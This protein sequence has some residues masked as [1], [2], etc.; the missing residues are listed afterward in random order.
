MH[1]KTPRHIFPD[2]MDGRNGRESMAAGWTSERE[3]RR[4]QQHG[5][6]VTCNPIGVQAVS[7]PVG[8]TG[9]L[10][11]AMLNFNLHLNNFFRSRVEVL[12]SVLLSHADQGLFGVCIMQ[13]GGAK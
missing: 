13:T 7:D 8:R 5:A 2:F 10:I 11:P 12:G 6:C 9:S 3:G 1:S 4:Q